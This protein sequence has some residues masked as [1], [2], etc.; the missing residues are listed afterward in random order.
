MNES[1]RE[2]LRTRRAATGTVGQRDRLRRVVLLLGASL[3]FL[4]A[5][6]VAADDP[7]GDEHEFVGPKK[8]K[9]CHKKDAIGNQYGAWLESKHAKA[10]ETLAGDQAAEWA[11]EAGVS[12]PQSDAKCVKCHVTAFGVEQSRLPRS[13]S[14]EDSVSCEACHGAG[15]DYRKKKVMIDRER[16]E[17]KGLVPQSEKVCVQCHNDESPAW[18]NDRYTLSDGS[19]VGFD[20]EQAVQIIAHPVPEGYDP[21][22]EGQAD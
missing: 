12:D 2:N 8:C 3:A 16:A 19:K 4:A 9:T 5:G 13:Y 20:Y 22:A 21:L 18:R 14:Y 7:A 10:F 1:I 6:P 17:A 15:K 11:A